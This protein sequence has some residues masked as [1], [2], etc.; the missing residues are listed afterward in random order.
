MDKSAKFLHNVYFWVVEEG[1]EEAAENIHAGIRKN[2]NSIPG[3]IRLETGK[4]AGT[5]RAVVD[6]SYGVSLHILFENR[7]AH[8]VYQKH[9]QHLQF[10]EECKAFWTRVQIYDSVVEY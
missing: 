2:L 1:S 6:N 4:P 9:S 5:E 7:E 3:I 10:I 8:D